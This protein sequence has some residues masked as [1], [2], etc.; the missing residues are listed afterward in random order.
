M[1]DLWKASMEVQVESIEGNQ[2]HWCQPNCGTS[3]IL[4][5]S[6][7]L[8]RALFPIEK[9]RIISFIMK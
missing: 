1:G 9:V 2:F 6:K 4:L 7:W 8:I 3:I 5:S